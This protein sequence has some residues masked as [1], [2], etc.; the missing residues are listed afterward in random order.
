MLPGEV[1]TVHVTLT[2]DIDKTLCGSFSFDTNDP[3]L[4]WVRITLKSHILSPLVVISPTY[5]SFSS[6][7]VGSSS[8]VNLS[9][10]NNG[11]DVLRITQA[12]FGRS[13]FSL[14]GDLPAPV[15]VGGLAT[16]PIVFAPGAAGTFTSYVDLYTNDTAHRT[17]R[18]PLSGTAV[19]PGSP[20]A[21]IGMKE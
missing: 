21:R 13:E 4:S 17:V 19:P 7:A 9:I 2:A 16:L 15:P 5:V 8:T 18:I 10:G 14:G 1:L 12:V 20:A 6:T 11:Q 3:I